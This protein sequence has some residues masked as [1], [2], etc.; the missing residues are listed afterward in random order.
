MVQF[1]YLFDNTCL[2]IWTVCPRQGHLKQL[3]EWHPCT[4]HN[5][6][7]PLQPHH[8]ISLTV[9]DKQHESSQLSSLRTSLT[10]QSLS[11]LCAPNP[12]A[13]VIVFRL[14][15]VANMLLTVVEMLCNVGS[16]KLCIRLCDRHRKP[17]HSNWPCQQGNIWMALIISRH[18]LYELSSIRQCFGYANN[19]NVFVRLISLHNSLELSSNGGKIIRPFVWNIQFWAKKFG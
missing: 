18:Q 14:G 6:P 13:I 4:D 19:I 17:L 10:M 1:L 12:P 5:T 3:S 2:T 7:P 8:L 11:I 15:N 9:P 16:K